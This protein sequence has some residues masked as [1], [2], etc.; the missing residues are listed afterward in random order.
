MEIGF[1]FCKHHFRVFCFSLRVELY[2]TPVKFLSPQSRTSCT[3]LHQHL[4]EH[5]L[6]RK[7]FRMFWFRTQKLGKVA[8]VLSW[9]VSPVW[10]SDLEHIF[11]M[12]LQVASK[13]CWQLLSDPT[14]MNSTFASVMRV[15]LLHSRARMYAKCKFEY[16]D[17]FP[18]LFGI[19]H[20]TKV[21]LTWLEAR[22]SKLNQV[23]MWSGHKRWNYRIHLISTAPNGLMLYRCNAEVYRPEAGMKWCC[24]DK[25]AWMTCWGSTKPF[26]DR[27]VAI[28]I[29]KSGTQYDSLEG[30]WIQL[31]SCFSKR[32]QVRYCN[33]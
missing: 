14:E 27:T 30:D 31:L 1:G 32:A 18:N 12:P 3:Q 6:H 28:R 21:F 16:S 9:R 17:A 2:K 8:K 4:F 5:I 13:V 10:W 33:K 11:D 29:W 15:D 23:P 20:G 19:L 26:R 22:Q 24:T 25:V 7:C